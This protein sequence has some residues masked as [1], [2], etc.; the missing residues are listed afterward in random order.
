[1]TA[2]SMAV[3]INPMRG[4]SWISCAKVS[5]GIARLHSGTLRSGG[6]GALPDV[7]K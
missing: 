3:Q 5:A 1:M 7:K 6:V 4:R 2:L